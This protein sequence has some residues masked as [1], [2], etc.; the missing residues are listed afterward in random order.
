MAIMLYKKF[1]CAIHTSITQLSNRSISS[2]IKERNTSVTSRPTPAH[3]YNCIHR[4]GFLAEPTVDT[5]CHVDVVTCCSPA[6]V[7][8]RFSFDCNGLGSDNTCV[9]YIIARILYNDILV[10]HSQITFEVQYCQ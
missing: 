1:K 4:T 2:S 10:F 5:F 6:A 3:L 8:T 7:S 9:F